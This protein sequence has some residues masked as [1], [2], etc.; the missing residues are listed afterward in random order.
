M[1]CA[2]LA[3]PLTH[4]CRIWISASALKGPALWK[5]AGTIGMTT[6][7]A[8]SLLLQSLVSQK[9]Y[10]NSHG[11]LSFD[12]WEA[13]QIPANAADKAVLHNTCL[14]HGELQSAASLRALCLALQDRTAL[15]LLIT[16]AKTGFLMAQLLL[17]CLLPHQSHGRAPPSLARA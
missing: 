5:T 6:A 11:H 12:T 8:C 17:S 10:L 1:L 14:V 4:I 7:F 2:D 16:R 3:T 13:V 9:I 15:T